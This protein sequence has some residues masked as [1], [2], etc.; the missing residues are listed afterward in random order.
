MQN[1]QTAY[2]TDQGLRGQN[3][4]ACV[5]QWFG[6][7]T[8]LLA[9]AD[10]MGG[11]S[12]G[13]VASQRVIE[14][15]IETVAAHC[16]HPD[17]E[18]ILKETLY[19]VVD[20]SHKALKLIGQEY[21]ELSG[22]GTT[23]VAIIIHKD[24]Y[25]FVNIGDSRIYLNKHGSFYQVTKDH[26]YL[27]EFQE[28]NPGEIIPESIINQYGHVVTRI[29]D[30]SGDLPDVYPEGEQDFYQLD[31]GDAL[32][33]CSDGLILNRANNGDYI[34][35]IYNTT[36]DLNRCCD[37]L[38]AFAIQNGSTDNVSVVILDN[39]S[40]RIQTGEVAIDSIH[41][42]KTIAIQIPENRIPKSSSR[43]S[44]KKM[45]LLIMAALVVVATLSIY[46]WHFG[47]FDFPKDS[48]NRNPSPPLEEVLDGNSMKDTNSKKTIDTSNV[49]RSDTTNQMLTGDLKDSEVE[50]DKKTLNKS[51][52]D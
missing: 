25:A 34:S 31:N 14:I 4:D 51:T 23:L 45:N 30:G 29:I 39:N 37:Q 44:N 20:N 10:G 2:R 17:F 27:R 52:L 36:A 50:T 41:E 43:Q 19:R 1:I 12:G 46:L 15:A 22:L 6:D 18:N 11:A 9:V 7:Q 28:Q 13:E 49:K 48:I 24:K 35:F 16:T 32:L 26:S 33:L 5:A 42:D 47:E 38:I 21:P 8:L 3:Q 40:K